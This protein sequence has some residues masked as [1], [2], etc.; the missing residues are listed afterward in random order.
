MDRVVR[1][2][3]VEV[4]QVF[5]LEAK[6]RPNAVLNFEP[7]F[8]GK[9]ASVL[10]LVIDG[11]WIRPDMNYSVVYED[12]FGYRDDDGNLKGCLGSMA[13]NESDFAAGFND[14]PIDEPL[15]KL[16]PFLVFLE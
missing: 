1:V 2:C 7:R 16:D 10:N 14:F 15:E 6:V 8:T 9:M 5:E 12:S 13:R 4:K 11:A 3:V